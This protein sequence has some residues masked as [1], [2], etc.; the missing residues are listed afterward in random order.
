MKHRDFL[1]ALGLVL[2]GAGIGRADP[3]FLESRLYLRGEAQVHPD[4]LQWQVTDRHITGGYFDESAT[5][6]VISSTSNG[7]A[8]AFVSAEMTWDSAARGRVTFDDVGF[9]QVIFHPSGMADVNQT[10]WYY[11]FTTSDENLFKVDYFIGIGDSTSQIV[12][13]QGF[14]VTAEQYGE[15]F[16]A[17]DLDLNTSGTLEIPLDPYQ[18]YTVR[19]I[20]DGAFNNDS[21]QAISSMWGDFAWVIKYKEPRH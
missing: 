9:I 6:Q 5:V 11:T 7:A 12:G 3:T 14:T 15:V 16:W 19:I 2:V 18:T 1:M 10:N 20:P 21:G 4:P 13:I 17:Q 8:S